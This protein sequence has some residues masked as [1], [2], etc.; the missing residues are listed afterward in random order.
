MYV[1]VFH[2]V[3]KLGNFRSYIEQ[4]HLPNQTGHLCFLLIRIK[5]KH[6]QHFAM[7]SKPSS[8]TG[9][10]AFSLKKKKYHSVFKKTFRNL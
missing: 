7:P 6:L 10:H 4:F 9:E 5:K 8:I 2:D 1:W 3:M